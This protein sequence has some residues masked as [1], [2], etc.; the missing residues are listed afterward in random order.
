MGRPLNKKYFGNR[1]VGSL[2]T[3]ADDK[4][5]GEGIA[6]INWAS[7]GTFRTTPS[8][9]AL[10]PPS[11]PGGVQATWS[12]ITY[13]VNGVVT[14]AGKTNLAVGWKGTSTMF[15][16]MVAVVTSTS[17]SNALFSI[18]TA[19]GGA[20][21]DTFTTIPN[22]GNTNTITLTHVGSTGGGGLAGTFTVDVNLHIIAPTI[23][24][25]GSGYTGDETFTVT[26]AGG[27][28]P[29]AGTIVLTTDTLDANGN[30]YASQ[31][32]D[33]NRDAYEENAILIFAKTTSGG[34]SLLGDIV[35]QKGRSVFKVKTTDGTANCLLKN[36]AVSAA[37]ECTITATDSAGGT[38]FVT[39]ISSHRCT[40]YRGTGTQFANNQSVPWTFGNATLNTTV[41]IPN[42]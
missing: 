38:Y 23:V 21:G 4:I 12:T 35:S 33:A 37:G 20:A 11:I 36:A 2:S 19:D 6:S 24:E 29:P 34:S 40:V 26:V 5:G 17:G 13:E 28:D 8:G 15:P 3:T 22:A 7:L 31:S 41:K 18:L 14:S 32:G 42:A 1:N 30:Q 27:M 10:P 9:L 25:Q 16:N 39:K